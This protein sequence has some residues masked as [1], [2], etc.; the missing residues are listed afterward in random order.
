[1]LL[2][3]LQHQRPE[4]GGLIGLVESDQ[5]SEGCCLGVELRRHP[6]IFLVVGRRMLPVS[7]SELANSEAGAVRERLRPL[8]PQPLPLGYE[9]GILSV[10]LWGA[11]GAKVVI[12]AGDRA[13][14]TVSGLV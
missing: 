2:D 12:V 5:C 1:M 9:G 8:N 10:A 3:V 7:E 4:G 14:R 11:V 13:D 6:V